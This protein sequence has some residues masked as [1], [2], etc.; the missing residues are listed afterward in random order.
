L[1]GQSLGTSVAHILAS[2]Q[3]KHVLQLLDGFGRKLDSVDFEVRGN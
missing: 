1:D 2:Q 3:G